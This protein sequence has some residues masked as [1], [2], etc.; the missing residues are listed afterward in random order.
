MVRVVNQA[1]VAMFDRGVIVV[2]GI[3]T[4]KMEE[5]W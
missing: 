3:K 5:R 2:E 1:D 4:V